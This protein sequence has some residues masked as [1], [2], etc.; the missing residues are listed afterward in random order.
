MR[1]RVGTWMKL[2]ALAWTAAALL[3]SGP[4]PAQEPAT[5]AVA[6]PEPIPVSGILSRADTDE[7]YAEKVTLDA[8]GPDP[9]ARLLPELQRIIASVDDKQQELTYDGLLQLPVSRQES[10]ARHWK[11]DA[12]RV[13]HWRDE[14]RR[15]MAPFGVYASQ[16]AQ[17]RA[18]WEATRGSGAATLS[19]ALAERVDAVIIQLRAAEQALSV[20]LTR[21]IE[22]GRRANSVEGR[23][24]SGLGSVTAAIDR[25]DSQLLRIDSPPLWKAGKPA[26]RQATVDGIRRALEIELRFVRD[27]HASNTGHHRELLIVLLLLLPLLLWLGHS[28]GPV[29]SGAANPDTLRILKRPFSIWLLLSM[30]AVLTFEQEL[31]LFLQRLALLIALV[32]VLRLVPQEGRKLLGFWPYVAALLY[33]LQHIG[34]VALSNTPLYRYFLFAISFVTLVLLAGQKWRRRR[35]P[36]TGRR[37]AIVRAIGWIAMTLLLGAVISIGVGNTSLGETLSSGVIN[38]GYFGL[39]VYTGTAVMVVLLGLLLSQ[40][41]RG[42]AREHASPLVKVLVRLLAAGAALGWVVYTLHAF[43][44]YRPTYAFLE[45][46]LSRK[47][48][49]G[50]LSLTLGNILVFFLAITIAVWSA[51]I[52][53]LLLRDEILS[54]MSLPRG[55]AESVSSL[56]YYFLILLG[57]FGALA[58]AGFQVGQLTLV[59]GALGVGIGF[60]L[61]NV[62]NNFVSGLIL[63]FERPIRPGDFVEISG[64]AGRVLTIGM[65]ATTIGIPDG[66]EVVVPNGTLLANNLVNW[67]LLDTNRRIEVPIDLA[68]GSDPLAAMTAM[69]VAATATPG[70]AIHPEPVVLFQGLADSSLKFLVQAWTMDFDRWTTIR[71]DLCTQVYSALEKAGFEIPFPQQDLHLRS[72]SQEAAAL[73]QRAPPRSNDSSGAARTPL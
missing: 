72:I 38:S 69:K 19:P 53:R 6:V 5:P 43:R 24:E 2:I 13:D 4:L 62:V 8:R 50:S 64:I 63:M 49:L 1:L 37:A 55:V 36:G 12:R 70:I 15:A 56:T 20:P 54:R 30:M 73:L 67:T 65:R 39:M 47:F 25:I 26:S 46:L 11:F 28:R 52:V 59:V 40:L 34:T 44:I 35:H 22:L 27:Y 57:F 45:D 3:T 51:R 68:Y 7:R 33:L 16:L 17:R 61:Q 31:P 48:N 21:Q 18:E 42:S 32:P 58:A 9:T 60:G 14:M 41:G 29:D 10:L 66:A 71:S 23:I